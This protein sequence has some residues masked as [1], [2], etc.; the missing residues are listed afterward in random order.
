MD[1]LIALAKPVLVGSKDPPVLRLGHPIKIPIQ[2][3]LDLRSSGAGTDR[4]AVGLTCK[5]CPSAV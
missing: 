2:P 3:L 1:Q 4:H 5:K